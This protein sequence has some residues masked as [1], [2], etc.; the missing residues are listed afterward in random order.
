MRTGRP[1]AELVLTDE[2]RKQLTSYA[3]SRSIPAALSARARIIVSSADGEANSGIA[4]RIGLTKATVGKWRARASSSGASPG[5][6]TMF[7]GASLAR[8]MTSASRS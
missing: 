6:M 8:S 5:S 4:E 2:E 7:G 3:R 1:K